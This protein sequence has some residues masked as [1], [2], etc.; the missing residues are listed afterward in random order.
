MNTILNIGNVWTQA[1]YNNRDVGSII[2][3]SLSYQVENAEHIARAMHRNWDGMRS[4]YNQKS[5]LFLTGL[6]PVV[7]SALI[8]AG[9]QFVE[10]DTRQK[11]HVNLSNKVSLD[12]IELRGFQLKA[13]ADFITATRGVAHL[14]TGAGK[15]EI[16][17]YL[18]KLLN[19]P[20]LFLTHKIVLLEQTARRFLSRGQAFFKDSLGIIG[21]GV[22]EPR[23]FTISTVQT[24]FSLIKKNP[25]L[26]SQLLNQYQFLII[27]EAHRSGASQFNIP[28]SYCQNAFYRLALTATPFMKTPYENMFLMG[29]TGNVATRVT[30]AELIDAG[31]LAR[32]Y[33]KF[34]NIDSP[35]LSSIRGWRNI[36]EKGIVDNENRNNVIITQSASL[37]KTG[38]KIL[39][40]VSEKNHGKTL[41]A[42]AHKNGIRAKYV[43]G[44]S[45]SFQRNRAIS[46]IKS[47]KLDMII[48]TNIFDEGVDVDEIN[49]VILAGGTKSAP[50]LFQRTGRA[51]RRKNED[52]YAIIID[53]IDNTNPA[54]HRHSIERYNHVKNEKGFTIL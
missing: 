29:V 16:A 22:F 3:Q 48:A 2:W 4:F 49:A 15:T 41:E 21:G 23:K 8:N 19:L 26:A 38:K 37:Q 27:D 20:T 11:P 31:I 12:G 40:I 42:K 35:N 14:A 33:F 46:L 39:T 9:V 25:K 24:L 44:D 7:E 32:P 54:L 51:L 6:L 53:F 1:Q 28:A 17:I 43:D 5:Q 52:N 30:N 36:Y 13:A 45:D 34:F 47:G 18:T 50:A 10:N